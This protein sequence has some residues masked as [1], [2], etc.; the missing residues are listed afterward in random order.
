MGN[1]ESLDQGIPLERVQAMQA[2][3]DQAEIENDIKVFE[4]AMHAFFNDKRPS[5]Y[6]PEASK[7]AYA[8]YFG[9]ENF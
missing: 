8:R 6:H 1:Y 4:G 7:D 3:L 2:V 5:G 9:L